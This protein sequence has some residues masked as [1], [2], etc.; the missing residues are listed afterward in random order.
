[1]SEVEK[2]PVGDITP[3]VKDESIKTSPTSSAT[4]LRHDYLF[5][6]WNQPGIV[7]QQG[8][9]VFIVIGIGFL[10]YKYILK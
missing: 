10:V 6:M 2:L 8:W 9:N 4:A 3:E 7:V 1:M 5:T